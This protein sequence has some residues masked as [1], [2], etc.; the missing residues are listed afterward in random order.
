MANEIT[1]SISATLRNG[2]L[3]DQF[4]PGQIL[5]DQ[6]AP[7]LGGYSQEISTDEQDVDF[8]EIA[9]TDGAV[10]I[11]RNLDSTNY[12]DVGPCTDGTSGVMVLSDRLYPGMAAVHVVPPDVNYRAQADTAAVQLYVRLY[13]FDANL[14]T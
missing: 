2:Y 13:P 8:G 7:G 9:I 1:L 10:L 5:M 11:L 3:V 14:G 12:V 4:A 6:N